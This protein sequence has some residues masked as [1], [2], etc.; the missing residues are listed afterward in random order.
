MHSTDRIYYLRNVIKYLILSSSSPSHD[1]SRQ[2]KKWQLNNT[3]LTVE[4]K[5]K[6]VIN[7]KPFYL[8][9]G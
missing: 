7:R 3:I 6:K 1:Y 8:N 9:A 5:N 4:Y 2:L